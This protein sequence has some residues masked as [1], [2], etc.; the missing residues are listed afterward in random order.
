LDLLAIDRFGYLVVIELKRD[1]S[2]QYADLQALRYASMVRGFTIDNLL[3]YYMDYLKK[4]GRYADESTEQLRQHILNFINEEGFEEL[5]NEPRIILV[6]QDFAKEVTSTV[7]WLIE[8]GI[9]ITCIKLTPYTLEDEIF[10]TSEEIIPPKEMKDYLI[11]IKTKEVEQEKERIVR[12]K[13]KFILLENGLVNAGDRIH[14]NKNLPSFITYDPD[15]KRFH[16][17]ISGNTGIGKG[18]IWDFDGKEYAISKLT[19]DIFTSLDPEGKG[20]KST[21][22][23]LYWSL[24]TGKTLWQVAEEFLKRN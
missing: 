23:N 19:N 20:L 11:S 9:D 15:D 13:T 8:H 18:V 12:T 1:D 4:F 6:A 17:T 2:A 24:D 3:P 14:L 16:G 10:V 21:N 22:G 7:L 5:S